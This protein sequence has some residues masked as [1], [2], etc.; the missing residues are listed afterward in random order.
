MSV[1]VNLLRPE[2]IRVQTAVSRNFLV[3]G[4]VTLAVAAAVFGLVLGVLQYFRINASHKK[5]EARWAVLEPRFEEGKKFREQLDKNVRILGELEA[6]SKSRL[7]WL[8]PLESLQQLVPTNLQF[9]RLT[10]NGDVKVSSEE[11]TSKAKPGTPVRLFAMRLE[12]QAVGALSDQDVISFVD[13]IRVS[14]QFS[15]WVASVK[16]QGMQLSKFQVDD[17][18][19][20]VRVFR[21][22]ANSKERM[23]K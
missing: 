10:I 17:G 21:I 16:L 9:T 14:D 11:P 8:G 19:E 6:W 22:H 4:G 18:E 12:G 20:G 1:R 23:M 5:M 3:K 13:K 2:E 7:N 15:P